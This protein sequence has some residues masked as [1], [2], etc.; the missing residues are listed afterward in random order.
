MPLM[1]LCIRSLERLGRTEPMTVFVDHK[2]PIHD[3]VKYCADRG[4]KIYPRLPDIGIWPEW[5]HVT[6]FN[7]IMA[8]L[9]SDPR[10][11]PDDYVLHL[12]TDMA[13]LTPEIFGHIDGADMYGFAGDTKLPTS[14]F[15]PWS[16][17]SGFCMFFK[18]SAVNSMVAQTWFEMDKLR[19]E[20]RA[21]GCS[22]MF[23][24]VTT[25]LMQ[26]TGSSRVDLPWL[27]S[28]DD[29]Q[30]VLHGGK[31]PRSVV[32]LLGMWTE[33]MGKPADKWGI[34]GVIDGMGGLGKLLGDK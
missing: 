4:L 19:E 20:I 6:S 15:G 22:F 25:Y 27:L 12:D 17:Y 33:F 9:G 30:T 13:F 5:K 26:L 29:I 1:D 16:W 3:I 24:V 10:I 2:E 14:R 31:E 8:Q 23:D 28:E 11:G 7:N 18:R 34:P 32:H 21:A